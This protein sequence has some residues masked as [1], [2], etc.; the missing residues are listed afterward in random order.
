MIFRYQT[1]KQILL[2]FSM[3]LAGCE[4]KN[5]KQFSVLAL[6]VNHQWDQK[7]KSYIARSRAPRAGEQQSS[8]KFSKPAEA[9]L[10]NNKKKSFF[11]LTNLSF[12]DTDSKRISFL[13]HNFLSCFVAKR[14]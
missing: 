4:T 11:M 13:T 14:K 6:G 10:F 12:N 2:I 1:G 3:T 7:E 9:S 5:N 8:G